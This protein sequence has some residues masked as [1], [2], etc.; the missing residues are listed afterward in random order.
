MATKPE[1]NSDDQFVDIPDD[2]LDQIE[3]AEHQDKAEKK[4]RRKM[5]ASRKAKQTQDASSSEAKKPKKAAEKVPE[6]S[7]PSSNG[8]KRQLGLGSDLRGSGQRGQGRRRQIPANLYRYAGRREAVDL[9]GHR[10]LLCDQQTGFARE[11]ETGCR[12]HL[13]AV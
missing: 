13:L 11:A 3:K 12:F 2:R 6:K 4:S 8:A 5:S 9:R 7:K 1:K 10:E